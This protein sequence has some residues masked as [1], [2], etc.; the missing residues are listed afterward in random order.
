MFNLPNFLE[1]RA[2]YSRQV[3]LYKYNQIKGLHLYARQKAEHECRKSA[4][5][6][7]IAWD[8]IYDYERALRKI[9]ADETTDPLE[10]L[11]EEQKEADLDE[12]RI[13]EN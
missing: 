9:E 11:C 2:A 8:L 5:E 4:N 6:C 12:C 10:K 13:H 1:K 7:A 3:R